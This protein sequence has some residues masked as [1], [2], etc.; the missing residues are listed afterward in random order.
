MID[1]GG[2]KINKN[3]GE[4]RADLGQS[5]LKLGFDFALIFCRIGLV[6]LVGWI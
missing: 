1:K 4:T 5:Q 3:R 2:I 6:E